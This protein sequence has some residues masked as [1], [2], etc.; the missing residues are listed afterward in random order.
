MQER[1]KFIR[2][3][4]DPAVEVKIK[5]IPSNAVF[6][7]VKEKKVLIKNISVGGGMLIGLAIK[8]KEEVDELLSGKE[9]IYFGKEFMG[10]HF[11]SKVFGRVAWLRETAKA[12]YAYEAGV[13]FEK[14]GETDK[15]NILHAMIDLAFKQRFI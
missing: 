6:T 10:L 15:E 3:S 12:D 5:I 7:V 11:R 8:N 13:A 14:I 1:R 9:K 4:L 2:L